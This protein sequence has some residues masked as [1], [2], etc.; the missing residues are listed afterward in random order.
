MTPGVASQ[1]RA[2]CVTPSV[3]ARRVGEAHRPRVD[4]SPARVVATASAATTPTPIVLDFWTLDLGSGGPIVVGTWHQATASSEF[5]DQI[6]ATRDS[7]S[8]VTGG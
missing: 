2:R 3:H 1:A 8:F 7:I 4:V 5:V 6:A